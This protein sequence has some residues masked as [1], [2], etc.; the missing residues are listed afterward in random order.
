MPVLSGLI[1]FVLGM[2]IEGIEAGL[3]LGFIASVLSA[4][5]MLYRKVGDLDRELK[6]LR[7]AMANDWEQRHGKSE[8]ARVTAQEVTANKSQQVV[9]EPVEPVTNH[10]NETAQ[11]EFV[12]FSWDTDQ[13][14]QNRCD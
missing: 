9:P 4:V 8:P 11:S 12:D 3:I 13:S 14:S 2:A 1:G 10:A 7:E 6:R 5:F